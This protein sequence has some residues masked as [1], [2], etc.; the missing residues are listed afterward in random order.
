MPIPSPRQIRTIAGVILLVML[1]LAIA[2]RQAASS[3]PLVDV[4]VAL[5]AALVVASY[6]I[7]DQSTAA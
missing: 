3:L 6:L 2:S 1:A 4:A 7:P 5:S